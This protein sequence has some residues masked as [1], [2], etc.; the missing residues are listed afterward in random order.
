M[1]ICSSYAFSGS[2]FFDRKMPNF[3]CFFRFEESPVRWK[4]SRISKSEK[5]PVRKQ[6]NFKI[7]KKEKFLTLLLEYTILDVV[8]YQVLRVSE[9]LWLQKVSVILW[10]YLNAIT[11]PSVSVII[12]LRCGDSVCLYSVDFVSGSNSRNRFNGH[13]MRQVA[14]STCTSSLSLFRYIWVLLKHY[15]TVWWP[16]S[17]FMV[18]GT[19]YMHHSQ[20]FSKKNLWN[21]MLQKSQKVAK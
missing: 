4:T 6:P 9:Q 11:K 18:A 3:I 2:S 1:S 14:R 21:E 15:T 16:N 12:N 19:S 17:R 13:C 5:I 8:L 20:L 10:S 7:F